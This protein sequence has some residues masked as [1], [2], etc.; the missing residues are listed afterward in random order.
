[1]QNRLIY[2]L[3]QNNLG[4][5]NIIL[6]RDGVLNFDSGYAYLFEEMDFNESLMSMLSKKKDSIATL[7]IA[8]N[9]S[10]ISR[11]FFSESDF[12]ETSKK[13]Y[14]YL[15][16]RN[17]LLNSIYYCP[18]SPTECCNCRKPKNGMIEAIIEDFNLQRLRTVFIG[19]MD[20]DQTAAASSNI[21]FRKLKYI[22]LKQ[23]I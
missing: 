5:Y 18:H 15:L 23:K 8:T 11:G 1:M 9:Q 20:T 21:K 13:I 4:V 16:S 17:I 6:D 14:Q 10:G 19:D 22:G 3:R 12:K 2:S 7:H